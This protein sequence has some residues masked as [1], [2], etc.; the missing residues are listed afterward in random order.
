[1]VHTLYLFIIFYL[2][3]RLSRNGYI[4][5]LREFLIKILV[6]CEQLTKLTYKRHSKIDEIRKQ[7]F[8]WQN[9]LKERPI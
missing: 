7:L 5:F 2:V 6:T 1:M 9:N 8:C 3:N 4:V